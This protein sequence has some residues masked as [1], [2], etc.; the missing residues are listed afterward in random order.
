MNLQNAF[1]ATFLSLALLLF[2]SLVTGAAIPTTSIRIYEY[3]SETHQSTLQAATLSHPTTDTIV[4]G[5][6]Y[7]FPETVP[8]AS[9]IAE[10]LIA[11]REAGFVP[12]SKH[13][14]NSID[15]SSPNAEIDTRARVSHMCSLSVKAWNATI[16]P[17]PLPPL[18]LFIFASSIVCVA[19][20]IS[21]MRGRRIECHT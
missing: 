18:S 6:A 14:Q 13:L 7:Y 5:R 3:K 11:L 15:S 12:S 21:K 4:K 20:I 19:T 8:D 10:R 2:S 1:P 16:P 9:E 17:L